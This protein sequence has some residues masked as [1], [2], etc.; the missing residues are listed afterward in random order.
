MEAAEVSGLI[1]VVAA[2]KPLKAKVEVENK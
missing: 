2:A 1:E